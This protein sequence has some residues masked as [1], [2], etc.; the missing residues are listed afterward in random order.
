MGTWQ[1][2]FDTCRPKIWYQY[3][4]RVHRYLLA[5]SGLNKELNQATTVC[6][7]LKRERE[8]ERDHTP[9]IDVQID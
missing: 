3:L 8:R 6:V 7:L 1:L 5:V 2:M 9:C 4:S